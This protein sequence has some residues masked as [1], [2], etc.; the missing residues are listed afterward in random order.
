MYSVFGNIPFKS[1]TQ[2]FVCP[3]RLEGVVGVLLIPL[4]LNK[5][6][7]ISSNLLDPTKSNGFFFITRKLGF[8]DFSKQ[9][10]QVSGKDNKSYG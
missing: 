1:R 7:F 4:S 10:F 6:P 9:S 3:L 5:A 2:S 8:I